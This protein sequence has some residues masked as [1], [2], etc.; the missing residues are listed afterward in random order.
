MREKS[1]I[2][3]TFPDIFSKMATDIIF[4]RFWVD[5]D[6]ILGCF[7]VLKSEKMDTK[8][9]SEK[10]HASDPKRSCEKVMQAIPRDPGNPGTGSYGPLKQFKDPRTGNRKGIRDTPLVPGGTVVDTKILQRI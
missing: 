5:L 2:L 3:G 6:S 8:K 10:S 1:K 9:H 7:F 4:H